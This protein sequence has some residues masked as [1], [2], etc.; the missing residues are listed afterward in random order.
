MTDIPPD[1]KHLKALWRDQQNEETQPLTLEIIHAR[2]FQSRVGRRNLVEYIACVFVIVTFGSYIVILPPPI[3]KLAS[4]SAD[5]AA[6]MPIW[7]A[8]AMAAKAFNWLCSPLSDQRT[9]VTGWSRSRTAKSSAG[10]CALKSLPGAPKLFISHQYPARS[11]RC[12]LS[13]VPFTTTRPLHGT[14]RNK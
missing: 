3:L 13:W 14:M 4:A 7:S 8:A 1:P 10:P 12:R 2:S 6:E 5:S 11:T 9:R